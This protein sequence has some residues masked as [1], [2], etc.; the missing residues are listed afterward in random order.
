MHHDR[1]HREASKAAE[2]AAST[3][4]Y[5]GISVVLAVLL[6]GIAHPFGGAP[7]RA[8][9]AAIPER[10]SAALHGGRAHTATEVRV[11]GATGGAGTKVTLPTRVSRDDLRLDPVLPEIGVRRGTLD[12]SFHLAG[13]DVRLDGE[14]CALCIRIGERHSMVQGGVRQASMSIAGVQG[15]LRGD[16]RF[17]ALA[18]ELG[19][20]VH[21]S[22]GFGFGPE[23]LG[24]LDLQGRVRG[25][26][27]AEAD[28]TARLLIGSH[29]QALDLGGGAMAGASARGEARAGFN[30]LGISIKQNVSGEAWAG[31]GVR[32]AARIEHTGLGFSWDASWGAAL[33]LGGAAS[34]G[35][36]VDVSG[37]AATLAQHRTT[38]RI[39]LNAALALVHPIYRPIPHLTEV[40]P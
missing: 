22:I 40:Q 1:Q 9:A 4:E 7:A 14:A 27:G 13:F 32:A 25:L 10:I 21:R 20:R 31:A 34:W 17:A 35:G 6:A 2:R 24:A 16:V 19:A 39:A 15:V 18:A 29:T 8:I 37:L 33:G 30:L 5:V 38:S 3:V 26:V 12:Q 36:S 23:Q 28:G 11:D